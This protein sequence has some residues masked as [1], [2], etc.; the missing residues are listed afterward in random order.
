VF[1]LLL[2]LL[3]PFEL[4]PLPVPLPLLLL[5]VLLFALLVL[6]LA[7]AP[8]ASY[9]YSSSVID[10][11]VDSVPSVFAPTELLA[12]DEGGGTPLSPAEVVTAGWRQPPRPFSF[13][14]DGATTWTN[15]I[16]SF[17]KFDPFFF[18]SL[19]VAVF[20]R[21]RLVALLGVLEEEEEEDDREERLLEFR[22]PLSSFFLTPSSF[23]VVVLDALL[24]LLL[25]LLLLGPPLPT[26]LPLPAFVFVASAIAVFDLRCRCCGIR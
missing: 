17:S 14:F 7:S 18:P 11:V 25:L 26:T 22:R 19:F 10:S 9:R 1:L 6:A 4:L 21:L 24:L 3:S 13:S 12:G 23:V 8:A 2:L 15:C 5:L 16:N 20:T